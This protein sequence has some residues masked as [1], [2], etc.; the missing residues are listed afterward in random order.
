MAR[1]VCFGSRGRRITFA[2]A[3]LFS[4]AA[5]RADGAD[6]A[7]FDAILITAA[8]ER[9]PQPLVDQLKTGGRLVVPLGAGVQDLVVATKTDRGLARET[10]TAVRFVPMTGKVRGVR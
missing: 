2:L 7:P 6:P 1:G 5:A 4:V 9:I 3:A 8:P 10:V